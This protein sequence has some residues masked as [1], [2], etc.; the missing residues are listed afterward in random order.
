[1]NNI[2]ENKNGLILHSNLTIEELDRIIRESSSIKNIGIRIDLLSRHFLGVEYRESTLIGSINKSE[3]FVINLNGVDCLT[4]IE[5]VEAMRLSNTFSE[6]EKNLKRV[7]YHNGV[8]S[9]ENRNHFFTDWSEYNSG[10]VEDVT[11]IIGG[12][13]ALSIPKRLNLKK[14]ETYFIHG[15]D[16]KNREI[17]YIPADTID[18]L[19]MD[20]LKTG[21]YAGVYSEEDGLDVSHV[22]IIIKIGDRVY[23]RH[24]SSAASNRKVI[25]EEC[26]GYITQKPGIVVL[27]PKGI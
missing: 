15:I 12:A 24:A 3:T 13:R 21:D 26:K 19:I 6:F 2:S 10:L 18:G 16:H 1:M 8:C 5:Y 27:R 9:F 25:D 17:K 4:F 14:D 11:A 7:R 22:G 23:L 20:G